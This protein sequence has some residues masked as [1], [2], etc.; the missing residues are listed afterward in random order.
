MVSKRNIA[1]ERTNQLEDKWIETP[2][3]DMQK[4]KK[5]KKLKYLTELWETQKTEK[6]DAAEKTF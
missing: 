6:R 1:E 4:R 2:Q 5:N 3:T